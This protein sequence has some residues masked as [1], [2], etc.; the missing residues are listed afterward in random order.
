[1][2]KTDYTLNHNFMFS[3]EMNQCMNFIFNKDLK[4]IDF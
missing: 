4:N 1:M 2:L 3:I